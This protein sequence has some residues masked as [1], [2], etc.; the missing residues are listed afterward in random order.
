MIE[1]LTRLPAQAAYHCFGCDR[2]VDG[3]DTRWLCDD[4][5]RG[6]PFCCGCVNQ[7][8]PLSEAHDGQHLD[9]WS[10]AA[11]VVQWNPL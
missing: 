3:D 11:L 6:Y 9:L 2:I 8:W 1:F 4:Q 10:S 7:P 5:L